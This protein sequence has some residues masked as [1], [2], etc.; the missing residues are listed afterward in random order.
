MRLCY[1]RAARPSFCGGDAL[2]FQSGYTVRQPLA[3]A[4]ADRVGLVAGTGL[5][6]AARDIDDKWNKRKGHPTA[7]AGQ[8]ACSTS[9][10][11]EQRSE[12]PVTN[13][14]TSP[15]TA[16]S[17]LQSPHID[18][19][20]ETYAKLLLVLDQLRPATRPATA[21]DVSGS[22]RRSPGA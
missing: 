12:G 19:P 6:P 14:Y 4:L 13:R 21:T 20:G 1:K 16:T 10:R 22:A 11:V 7:W 2:L 17:E 3:R 5:S 18:R 9:K 15:L 8:P